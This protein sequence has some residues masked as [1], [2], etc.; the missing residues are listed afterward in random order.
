M[1]STTQPNNTTPKTIRRCVFSSFVSSLLAFFFAQ[2]LLMMDAGIR[3]EWLAKW[4]SKGWTSPAVAMRVVTV[5]SVA[6]RAYALDSAVLY[7]GSVRGGT[8][9]DAPR[10]PSGKKRGRPKSSPS[11]GPPKGARLFKGFHEVWTVWRAPGGV[12]F[13][14][15]LLLDRYACVSASGFFVEVR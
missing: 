8:N 3:K 9:V 4:W 14:F 2:A 7:E 5:Q 10:P 15:Y 1:K 11:S 6:F 12:S 13:F